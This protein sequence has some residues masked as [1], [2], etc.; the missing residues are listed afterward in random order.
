MHACRQAAC[1]HYHPP[2]HTHTTHTSPPP[3]PPPHTHKQR[4]LSDALDTW[5]S[6]GGAHNGKGARIFPAPYPLQPVAARPIMLD[7]AAAGIDYP[8]IAHRV[9]AKTEQAGQTSTFA[10]LFGWGAGS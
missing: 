4:Y 5:E 7:T 6:F 9:G 3:P 1:A 2:T 8:S 10:R